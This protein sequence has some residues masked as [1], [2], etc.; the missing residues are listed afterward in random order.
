MKFIVKSYGERVLGIFI[1]LLIICHTKSHAQQNNPL[2]ADTISFTLSNAEKTFLDS[3]L[4]LLAQKYN[5]EAQ[6][7]LIIQAKLFSNP[8]FSFARGP[9]IPI[10]DTLSNYPRTNLFKNSENQA[11]ISQLFLLAGKRNKN[12][13]IAQA[14][15]QLSEYQFFDLLRTLKYTLR[16]DFFNIYY[17][18]ET[19][20]VYDEELTALQHVVD[21]YKSVDGKGYIAE[22]EVV[23]VQAQLYSLQSEYNDLMN[24]IA[25]AQSELKLVLQVKPNQFIKPIVDTN[26][27]D[28]LNPLQYPLETLMDSAYKNRTDLKIAKENTSLSQLNYDL[29]KAM[30]IPDI[31]ANIS[32]D[33]QGSYATNFVS[34]G[35]SIDL[36]FFNKNQGN[37][38]SSKILI[39]NALATQ[40][41]TEK[42]IE[43]NVYH[44]LMKA[45]A[46]DKL[47]K[48]IDPK[49]Q[50]DFQRL[51]H[52][53]LLNYQRRNLGLLEFL[54]FYDSY[55]Q[56]IIQMNNIKFNRVSAFEDLNYY[57]G[58]NFYN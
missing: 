54:D 31:T 28:A 11:S 6:K 53:V 57:T 12:I 44:S 58:T 23:R 50:G 33:R 27:I 9:L 17:L 2:A 47:S 36:P 48:K 29:Q 26:K 43:E 40:K 42:T 51:N 46:Q 1:L 18:L 24:L 4:L 16:T 55:K 22:K 35:F 19:A 37:I 8:N 38:K 49:F 25:N 41:S 34:G 30:K 39:D 56:N 15:A 10:V 14:N 21:A 45:L 13:K 32:Y 52:E 5:I 3:N 7:A 20:K